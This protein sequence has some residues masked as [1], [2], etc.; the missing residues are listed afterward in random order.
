MPAGLS[1]V[2]PDVVHNVNDDHEEPHEHRHQHGH[3]RGLSL[4]AAEI[5]PGVQKFDQ[6]LSRVIPVRPRVLPPAALADHPHGALADNPVH[7]FGLQVQGLHQ[8]LEGAVAVP[9][10]VVEARLG[11]GGAELFLAGLPQQVVREVQQA[12]LRAQM[13]QG[14]RGQGVDA[15]VGQVQVPQVRQVAEGAL[16]NVP[17]VVA[18]QVQGDRSGWDPLWN[19]PQAGVRAVHRGRVRRTFT[20]VWTLGRHLTPQE[21]KQERDTQPRMKSHR[22]TPPSPSAAS[23]LAPDCA[24]HV[25][26]APLTHAA[27]PDQT[28]LVTPGV[29]DRLREKQSAWNRGAGVSASVRS[30]QSD[31]LWQGDYDIKENNGVKKKGGT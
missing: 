24:H 8:L 13:S 30:G 26:I 3:V 10:V 11:L 16:G 25:T 31:K 2:L 15:V 29:S 20:A 21:R 12:Q 9:G 14:A 27:G 7:R 1:L 4:Q 17:N 5:H 6:R 28:H 18:F 23:L 22:L 19:L